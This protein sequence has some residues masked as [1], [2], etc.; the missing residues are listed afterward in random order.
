MN[1]L[2]EA[3]CN[4]KDEVTALGYFNRF[5]E[6]AELIER[7]QQEK[8]PQVYQGNGQYKAIY[9]LD[10]NGMG[11]VRKDGDVQVVVISDDRLAVVSCSDT[12]PMIDL[13]FPLRLVAGVP[14]K[15]LHDNAFSDDELAFE[16]MAILGKRQTAIANVSSVVGKVLS[17]DTDRERVWSGEVRGVD[18][19]INLNLSYIA[20]DFTL[21]MR[22][23]LDCVRQNCNY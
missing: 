4:I 12:N 21:T 9:D 13:V 22:T 11:Y 6:Y 10:V 19:M 15:Q 14:K 1:I 20:M 8:Y 16:I 5:Y 17:Y 7:G 23:N 3:L 2:Q 18:K